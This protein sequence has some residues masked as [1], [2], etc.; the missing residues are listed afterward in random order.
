MDGNFE[1]FFTKLLYATHSCLERDVL[2]NLKS[3]IKD[4]YTRIWTLPEE[5]RALAEKDFIR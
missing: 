4:E 2:R 5:D 3:A 1:K